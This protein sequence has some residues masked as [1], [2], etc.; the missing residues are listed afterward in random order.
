MQQEYKE[1]DKEQEVGSNLGILNQYFG[2][3]QAQSTQL[4]G[5]R[6]MAANKVWYSKARA[7][8]ATIHLK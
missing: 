6:G 5:K 8:R 7:G 1:K 3:L 2:V 4:C